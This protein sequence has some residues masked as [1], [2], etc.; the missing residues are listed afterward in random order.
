MTLLR[1][2]RGVR[3]KLHQGSR[4]GYARVVLFPARTVSAM[5]RQRKLQYASKFDIGHASISIEWSASAGTCCAVII[6]GPFAASQYRG[7]C[8]V[9]DDNSFDADGLL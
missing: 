1:S 7:G 6:A 4:P 5:Q 2:A 9:D 3:L 8:H